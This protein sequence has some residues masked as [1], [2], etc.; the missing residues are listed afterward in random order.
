VA[1]TNKDLE[2]MVAGGLFRSDLLFRLRTITIELPPLSS[3]TEDIKELAM[4]HMARVCER[5][6]IGTKGSR[7]SSSAP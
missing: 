2:K 1:A 3:R 5:Y 6:G 7:R 4:H